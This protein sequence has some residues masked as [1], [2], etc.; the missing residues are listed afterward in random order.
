M[1]VKNVKKDMSSERP[2]TYKG[3]TATISYDRTKNVFCGEVEGL[4][5]EIVFY[6]KSIEE[7]ENKFEKLIDEYLLKCEKENIKPQE[8]YSGEISI[9]IEPRLHGWLMAICE[10]LGVSMSEFIENAIFT[11]VRNTAMLLEVMGEDTENDCGCC[12]NKFCPE[13]Y[14]YPFFY[15]G[16][17]A[18]VF[19][20]PEDEEVPF[21]GILLNE[22]LDKT[23]YSFSGKTVEEAIENFKKCVDDLITHKNGNDA[24]CVP[25]DGKISFSADPHIHYLISL[26]CG[27]LEADKDEYLSELFLVMFNEEYGLISTYEPELFRNVIVPKTK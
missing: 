13:Q 7:L 10:E 6:G 4:D 9:R 19:E 25:F 12:V 16:Y 14:E 17:G 2:F 8:Q 1:S 15:K 23:V 22:S 11:G 3:Y 5:Y 26:L 20:K 18:I 21:K 27:A 24:L